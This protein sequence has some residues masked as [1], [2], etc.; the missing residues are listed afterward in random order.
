MFNIS[1]KDVIWGYF[2]QFFSIASGIIILPLVLRLL[3]PEEI[4][5]NYLM[6]TVG[7]L[8][9]LFD[10][11][12]APQIARNITYIFSGSQE[13][14]SEG[15]TDEITPSSVSY[16][17]LANMIF[18]VRYLYRRLSV[19]V[20]I[21][22]IS[23]GTYYI[24]NI[25]EG[26]STVK[27]SLV[28]WLVYSVSIFFNIYY[29]YYTSLLTGKGQV[30]ESR[31]AVVYSKITLIMLT[32][33]L[34]SLGI[35]LLGV[36][37]A[38]LIASFVNRIISYN[39]FFTPEI[40]AKINAFKYN[41]QEINK[42]FKIIWFNSKKVGL[43]NVAGS[44]LGYLTI[45]IVGLFMSLKEV[46]SYG[47]MVQLSN[48][49]SIVSITLFT[50]YLP[51]MSYLYLNKEY[52]NLTEQISVTVLSFYIIFLA[53]MVFFYFFGNESLNVIQSKTELPP[54]WIVLLFLF[55]M[56]IEKNQS[57]FSQI[58]LFENRVPFMGAALITGF[59]SII[60]VFTTL[61][62]DLGFLGIVLAQGLPT[63]FY[64]AWKWPLVVFRKLNISYQDIIGMGFSGIAESFQ[65]K[66]S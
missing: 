46:A 14:K 53:G 4:G 29:S 64:S 20:L 66:K 30:T 24:Y 9:S 16:S 48:V 25:T 17:L 49:L 34:L 2:A 18:T 6:I 27:N 1:K 40:N 58:L 42:L 59:I 15:I 7:A 38:N 28:I 8:A 65:N 61:Y 26:F 35:G 45:F 21:F 13:L 63:L 44:S 50:T 62:L 11:G 19:I 3:T 57:L 47:L 39:F 51:K 32:I 33:L 41:R 12:F 37:V 60:L 36:A 5:M 31:K 54:K 43:I 52:R 55:F 56:L 22:M 10:F 23:I